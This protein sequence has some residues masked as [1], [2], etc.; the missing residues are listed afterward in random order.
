MGT[1]Q[2]VVGVVIALAIVVAMNYFGGDTSKKMAQLKTPAS[3]AAPTSAPKIPTGPKPKPLPAIGSPKAKVVIKAFVESGNHCHQGTIAVVQ[4][5]AKLLPEQIRVEFVDT[6]THDGQN[7]AGSAQ[8]GC[9]A[10]MQINGKQKVEYKGK[11]GKKHEVNFHGPLSMMSPESLPLILEEELHKQYGNA[12]SQG[13]ITR[14]SQVIKKELAKEGTGGP[15]GEGQPA[16]KKQ[17]L[18]PYV[19]TKASG[20]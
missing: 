8:I 17:E 10:G 12:V 14:L 2:K 20:A 7:A 16:K 15:G 3:K 1:L 5:V 18:P 11:D 19:P 4:A 9:Q 13:D 6:S